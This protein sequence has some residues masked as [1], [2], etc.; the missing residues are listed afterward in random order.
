MAVCS[1]LAAVFLG[2]SPSVSPDGG[3]FA[4][5]W[6]ERIYIA[7]TTGGVARAVTG[8][9]FH[10]TSP[11]YSRDGGTIYF[12]SDRAYYGK[13][14][15][16]SAG[17][18]GVPEL[19]SPYSD[20]MEPRQELEDGALLAFALTG[21]D[22]PDHSLRAVT[23][24]RGDAALKTLL[25]IEVF[26]PAVTP[27]GER[28]LFR[29]FGEVVRYR[30][31]RSNSSLSGEI[32]AYE[33]ATGRFRRLVADG[34]DAAL[35]KPAP[36]GSGFYFVSNRGGFVRNLWYRSF[37]EGA[38]P[39]AVTAFTGD[40]VLDYSVSGNGRVIVAQAGPCFWRVGPKGGK[41]ARLEL[42]E[43]EEVPRPHRQE[44]REGYLTAWKRLGETYYDPT[45]GGVD[46]P[47]VRE[48]YLPFAEEAPT[49]SEFTRAVSL[50]ISELDASHT[51]FKP[52]PANP[53]YNPPKVRA[54]QHDRSGLEK[55]KAVREANYR[56]KIEKRR[57]RVHRA[58]DGKVGYIH[59]ATMYEPGWKP[60]EKD[61]R[62][63]A[64]GREKLILDIRG[65]RGGF[66]ADR[67]LKTLCPVVHAS[68]RT[69]EGPMAYPWLYRGEYFDGPIVLLVD[70]V[71]GSNAEIFAHAIRSLGRGPVVGRA[72]Q[73]NVI[74]APSEK[75]GDL[76]EM[77]IPSQAV[78][79][80]EGEDMEGHGVVPDYP[81]ERTP[82]DFLA[83]RDPQLEK[84]IEVISTQRREP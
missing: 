12:R 33:F 58:T 56:A 19:Y 4:F 59:I 14:F 44:F 83:G 7:P 10:D 68:F 20:W 80:K 24:R 25:G 47:A 9:G 73:G 26:D 84:A 41:P 63:E 6:A 11:V 39:V 42:V 61:L 66:I 53:R 2:T 77:L 79:T 51:G 36:D 34:F 60:Y 52:D 40:E 22:E 16:V 3:S 8:K 71:C 74:M 62:T 17:G 57:E 54:S 69:R 70:E 82:A 32:W 49:I 15:S 21:D 72:T 75:I 50:M 48:R 31:R 18:N 43:A 55:L 45:M 38:A 5:E 76:G 35:P 64:Q 46:W 78:F 37:E 81:V 27:G 30:R 1:I 23:V 13:I 28:L 29:R 65:N 67:I